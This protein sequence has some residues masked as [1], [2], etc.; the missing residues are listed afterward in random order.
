MI[1]YLCCINCFN[2]IHLKVFIQNNS[3]LADKCDFCSSEQSICLKPSILLEKFEF[4]IDCFEEDNNGN[5]LSTLLNDTY[6]IFHKDMNKTELLLQKILGETYREKKYKP[7]FDTS[8]Y[9]K[10]W[11]Q[12]KDEI[13]YENR[14][15]PV[16]SIYS[17]IFD[18]N[19]KESIFF[20]LLSQLTKKTNFLSS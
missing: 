15:F 2:D 16:N 6:V 11:N 7:R 18:I 8:S 5:L 3:Q 13:K 9:A 1:T 12:F 20:E 19:Q 10:Q 14:F 17:S 4:L